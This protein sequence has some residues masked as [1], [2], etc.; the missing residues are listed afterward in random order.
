MRGNMEKTFNI[1]EQLGTDVRTRANADAIWVFLKNNSS[2]TVALD[3]AGVVFIS[4]SFADE[5]CNIMDSYANVRLKNVLGVVKIML[6]TVL[7]SRKHK[8]IREKDDSEV[9]DLQDMKSLSSFLS[10][11]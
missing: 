9:I 6:D 10:T 3:F 7:D 4:R 2:E 11:I 5:I 8:R 1:S